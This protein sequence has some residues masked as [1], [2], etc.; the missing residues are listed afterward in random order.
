[1]ATNESSDPPPRQRN[2]NH[3]IVIKS[4]PIT[5]SRSTFIKLFAIAAAILP[6]AVSGAAAAMVD[7]ATKISFEDS[8]GG[9]SLFGVGVRKKGPIKVSLCINCVGDSS[10]CRPMEPLNY[11]HRPVWTGLRYQSILE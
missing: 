1:M 7:P 8:V 11:K 5:M 2:E 3:S 9:L 4:V 6:T 10:T